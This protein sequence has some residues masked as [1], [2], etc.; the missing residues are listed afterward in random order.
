MKTRCGLRCGGREWWGRRLRGEIPGAAFGFTEPI[1]DNVTEAVTGSPADR[2]VI[3]SGP[4]LTTLRHLAG[5]APGI[6]RQVPG[7]ADTAFEQE[8]DQ[9]QLRIRIDR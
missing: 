8:A 7:S 4:N 9:A 2:A 5:K 3:I 6:L 1:I